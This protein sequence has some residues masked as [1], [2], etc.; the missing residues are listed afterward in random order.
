M[1]RNTTILGAIALVGLVAGP[2][3]AGSVTVKTD[4]TTPQAILHYGDHTTSGAQMDGMTVAVTYSDATTQTFTWATTTTPGGGVSG[5]GFSLG[6]P[7]SD[8]FQDSPPWTLT[9]TGKA[10]TDVKLDGF[11]GLTLF[12]KT[13]PTN[14]TDNSPGKTFTL[15]SGAAS[16]NLTV[17][18]SGPIGVDGLPPIGPPTD[19]YR[20]LDISFSTPFS[21]TLT[22]AADTDNFAAISVTPV[23]EP[24]PILIMGLGILMMG[25]LIAR[26]RLGLKA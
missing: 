26:K 14:G 19:V 10:I 23:P 22:Y 16:E 5:G 12:D 15:L 17:T 21:G 3:L 13:P 25:G 8:T 6:Y 1:M 4:D 2:T 7:G 11:P 20:W 9:N 18:Y 24:A